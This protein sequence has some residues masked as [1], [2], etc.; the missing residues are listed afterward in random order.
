MGV[1]APGDAVVIDDGERVE[2]ANLAKVGGEHESSLCSVIT[3]R[4]TSRPRGGSTHLPDACPPPAA[5]S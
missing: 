4:V 5:T 3:A 1:P 2:G